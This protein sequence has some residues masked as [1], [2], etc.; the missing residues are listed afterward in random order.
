[1]KITLFLILL[2]QINC[3]SQ[4]KKDW[5]NIKKIEVYKT[6]NLYNG[7]EN[8]LTKL[9]LKSEI[10]CDNKK[11]IEI[12]SKIEKPKF[13]LLIEKS[14]LFFR[15]SFENKTVNYLVYKKHGILIELS[16]KREYYWLKDVK[17]INIFIKKYKL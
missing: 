15:I 10:T 3:F 17:E 7:T 2:L 16:K 4:T 14:N 13:D 1:M 6:S 11:L 8:E 12:L 5:N 9:N